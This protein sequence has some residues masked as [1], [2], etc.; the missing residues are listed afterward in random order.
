MLPSSG[1]CFCDGA[2]TAGSTVESTLRQQPYF[3]A[4]KVASKNQCG[5]S[6]CRS[7]SRLCRA[8]P[9]LLDFCNRWHVSCVCICT[10]LLCEWLGRVLWDHLFCC[11]IGHVCEHLSHLTGDLHWCKANDAA[12]NTLLS[13]VNHCNA[14]TCRT[15]VIMLF[16]KKKLSTVF[17][18]GNSSD[19]VSVAGQTVIAWR[20]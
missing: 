17:L 1:F 6:D 11:H 15:T 20:S 12:A 19:R 5:Q 3:A 14:M 4:C 18:A 9:I 2:R 10:M 8:P 7:G 16:N 13:S